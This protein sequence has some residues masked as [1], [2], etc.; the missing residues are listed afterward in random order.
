MRFC[1][2][3][4]GAA[5]AL[6]MVNVV[7]PMSAS[8]V[9]RD[10]PSAVLR[11]GDVALNE[12]GRLVGT[13]VNGNGELLAD[14]RVT[15]TQEGRAVGRGLSDRQGRFQVENV[16]GGL[17][18]VETV[19]TTSVFRCWSSKAAPPSAAQEILVV[20]D[21]QFARGQRPIGEI[22]TNPLLIGLLVAAAIAIPI[23][24]H[25]SRDRTAG[26]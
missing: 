20:S 22:F 12:H 21:S 16:R 25:N 23:A 8:A 1:R 6:A 14:V 7:L 26:S 11:I 24:V 2:L 9:D 3:F 4:K 17:C 19:E 5:V 13:V 10:P 18:Q 15:V